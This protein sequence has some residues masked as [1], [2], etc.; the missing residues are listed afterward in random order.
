M[1][2]NDYSGISR[3]V[4]SHTTG[5]FV[6]YR[7]IIARAGR[8]GSPTYRKWVVTVVATG[9]SLLQ[10]ELRKSY[11]YINPLRQLR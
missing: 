3:G 6:Y 10:T 2:L 11:F 9:R 7:V 5:Y 8:A 1:N 4:L